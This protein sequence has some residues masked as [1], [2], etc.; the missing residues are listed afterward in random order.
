MGTESDYFL[1]WSSFFETLHLKTMSWIDPDK[2]K[3]LKIISQ[4]E[5][6]KDLNLI[7]NVKIMFV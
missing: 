7:L 3:E 6:C 1:F 4:E 2:W 5:F